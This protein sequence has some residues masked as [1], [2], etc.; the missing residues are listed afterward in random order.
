M[1]W[2]LRGVCGSAG[3]PSCCRPFAPCTNALRA[4]FTSSVLSTFSVGVGRRQGCPASPI[5]F[6]MDRISKHSLGRCVTSLLFCRCCGSHEKLLVMREDR[7]W[8]G[9]LPKPEC[10]SILGSYS[11]VTEGWSG[12]AVLGGVRGNAGHHCGEEI[13]QSVHVLT[14]TYGHELWVA[15]E[16]I[17]SRIQAAEMRFLQ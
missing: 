15:T 2:T 4:A 1:T 12:Q 7:G 10:S 3:F 16:R 17:R 5:L 8:G 14:F 13:Y 11:Q 6:F 9:L